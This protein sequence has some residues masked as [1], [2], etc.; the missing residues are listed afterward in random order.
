VAFATVFFAARSHLHLFV[1]THALVVKGAGSVEQKVLGRFFVTLGTGGERAVVA[2]HVPELVARRTTLHILGED[3]LVAGPATLVCGV[4]HAGHVFRPGHL[5]MAIG[6]FLR[7]RLNIRPV[8]AVR[9]IRGVILV[10]LVIEIQGVKFQ[11]VAIDAD[12]GVGKGAYVLVHII[13]IKGNRVAGAATQRFCLGIIGLV[14]ALGALD[15]VVAMMG[16]MGEDDIASRVVKKD[17]DWHF[18]GRDRPHVSEDG[19]KDQDYGG[20][21]NGKILFR[22]AHISS[23]TSFP[24]VSGQLFILS[25]DQLRVARQTHSAPQ[26]DRR[27][28]RN[29]LQKTATSSTRLCPKKRGSSQHASGE[30]PNIQLMFF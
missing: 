4:A 19:H 12:R 16:Q 20:G 27:G 30:Y 6:A 10:G 22:R 11:M 17:A 28:S 7:L 3:I 23:P 24:V 5:G 2:V 29:V 15:P 14:M 9:A 26:K 1:T 13:L 18:L 25:Q 8:M 21:D